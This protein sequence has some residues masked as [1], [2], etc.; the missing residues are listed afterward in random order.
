MDKALGEAAGRGW[1][2]GLPIKDIELDYV[3]CG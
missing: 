3:G 2:N 1:I